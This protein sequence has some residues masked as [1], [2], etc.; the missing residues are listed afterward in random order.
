MS[1]TKLDRE[2]QKQGIIWANEEAEMIRRGQALYGA[3]VKNDMCRDPGM[4]SCQ[5]ER[6]SGECSG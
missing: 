1:K 4:F 3:M 2:K 6:S 5:G